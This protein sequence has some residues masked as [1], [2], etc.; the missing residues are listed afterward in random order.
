MIAARNDRLLTRLPARPAPGAA[1]APARPALRCAIEPASARAFFEAA[2]LPASPRSPAMTELQRL[3]QELPQNP[4]L[5]ASLSAP[6]L[7]LA[8]GVAAAQAAGYAIDAEEA[9]R[10]LAAR[11]GELSAEELDR[12]SGGDLLDQPMFNK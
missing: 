2:C 9:Q 7:T 6:G 1:P 8:Q 12:L 3:L 11:E 5:Q 4:S 10:F